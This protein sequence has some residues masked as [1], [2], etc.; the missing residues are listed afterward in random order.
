MQPFKKAS[1]WSQRSGICEAFTESYS[2]II[3]LFQEFQTSKDYPKT[4]HN[5]VLNGSRFA[6][7]KRSCLFVA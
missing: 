2:V 1:A 5:E 7:E 4:T 3:C 6:Q